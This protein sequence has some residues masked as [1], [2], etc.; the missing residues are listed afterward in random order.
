MV[1]ELSIKEVVSNSKIVVVK[2]YKKRGAYLPKER[3]LI[4][5]FPLSFPQ[6]IIFVTFFCSVFFEKC[7]CMKT[8]VLIHMK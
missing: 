3:A 5:L 7:I 6:S 8:L 1:I 2:R 4:Q